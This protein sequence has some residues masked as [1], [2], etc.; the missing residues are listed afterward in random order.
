MVGN[1][2][3]SWMQ[4]IVELRNYTGVMLID[5]NDELCV[6]Y[7]KSNVQE[8]VSK[9]G[10]TGLV[11]MEDEI[12]LLKINVLDAERNIRAVRKK[13]P[14]APALD[15][16]VAQL[17]KDILVTRQQGEE[18]AAQLEDPQNPQRWRALP[19]RIKDK[20]EL[21]IKINQLEERL[22]GKKEQLLERE[23]ILEEVCALQR[24]LHATQLRVEEQHWCIHV[25]CGKLCKL[26]GL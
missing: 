10:D 8:S 20:D 19:G 21:R 14:K 15:H 16:S 7:E 13:Q 9:H 18:L 6:L 1:P 2:F 17:Q 26:Q 12:R 3:L 5:R 11:R 23:L 4:V 22:N 24:M 25:S